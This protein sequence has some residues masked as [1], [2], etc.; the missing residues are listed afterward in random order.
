MRFLH[1]DR[2]RLRTALARLPDT[3]SFTL[4]HRITHAGG[5][6]RW[7]LSRGKLVRD[8]DGR[9]LRIDGTT[10]DVTR[11]ARTKFALRDVFAGVG[12]TGGSERSSPA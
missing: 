11:Q 5:S 2:D 8:R 7:A 1:D 12:C 6:T 3:D 10:T 4:E 9:P